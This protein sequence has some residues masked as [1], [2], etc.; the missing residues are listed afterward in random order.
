MRMIVPSRGGVAL[1]GPK[2][3]TWGTHPVRE[4]EV[5]NVGVVSAVR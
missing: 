4:G 3:G 5:Y 2:N 1:P